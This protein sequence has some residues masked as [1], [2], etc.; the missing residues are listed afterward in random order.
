MLS[1]CV[2]SVSVCYPGC[3]TSQPPHVET[4]N[5]ALRDLLTNPDHRP[6]IRSPWR[7]PT[8]LKIIGSL[9][10]TCNFSNS[11]LIQLHQY[12]TLYKY[13]PVSPSRNVARIVLTNSNFARKLLWNFLESFVVVFVVF[14]IFKMRIS[15][16]KQKPYYHVGENNLRRLFY[17]R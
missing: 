10:V 17:R 6:K 13:A 14:F 16:I 4:Y 7:W 15:K 1:L 11:K 12:T 8:V 5:I 9:V 3:R 2:V